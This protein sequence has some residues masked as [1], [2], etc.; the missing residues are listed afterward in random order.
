MHTPSVTKRSQAPLMLAAALAPLVLSHAQA[1]NAPVIPAEQTAAAVTDPD[2][3]AARFSW[4]DPSLEGP[5][6]SRDMSG[7]P[8]ERPEQYGT[9]R[10]VTA[11]RRT[12]ST[13]RTAGCRR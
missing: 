5:F 13:P 4:G 7:I 11:T 8:M 10:S 3:K 9:R 2:W 12:S 6:T 1:Q